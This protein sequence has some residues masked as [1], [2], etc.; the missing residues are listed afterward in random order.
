MGVH[1]LDK[2]YVG[3]CLHELRSVPDTGGDGTCLLGYQAEVGLG[4][5]VAR[6]FVAE[7]D[8]L[9]ILDLLLLAQERAIRPI[10]VR[11][12]RIGS[13]RENVSTASVSTASVLPTW[14]SGSSPSS[15][16][17]SLSL[18]AIPISQNTWYTRSS[19]CGS[20][21]RSHGLDPIR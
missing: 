14:S 4:E 17:P 6:S 10:S 1:Q 13:S 2:L 8:E 18:I 15:G 9:C 16:S 21:Q 20:Y 11:Y 3:G 7:L 5:L 19:W 12:I